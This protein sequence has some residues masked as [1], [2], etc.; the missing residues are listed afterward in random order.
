MLSDYMKQWPFFF[1]VLAPKRVTSFWY[2]RTDCSRE[3]YDCCILGDDRA[4]A[5]LFVSWLIV[6]VTSTAEI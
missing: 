5:L 4:V 1:A 3:N 6:A 2:Q